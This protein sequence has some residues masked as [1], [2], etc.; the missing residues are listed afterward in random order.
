MNE[1]EEIFQAG[2]Q[3][4]R[5]GLMSLGQV[6]ERIAAKSADKARQA[7]EIDEAATR[8]TERA[9]VDAERAERDQV[10]QLERAQIAGDRQIDVAIGVARDQVRRDGWWAGADGNRV[11]T[12]LSLLQQLD[13]DPRAADARDIM[14]ERIRDLYGIDT[15]AISAKHPT[16]PIDQHNALTNAID[17]W[18]A[19][20]RED[21]LAEEERTK[22]AE[23][24]VSAG[25]G[26]D[27]SQEH[28]E[29]AEEHEERADA[30]RSDG[31]NEERQADRFEAEQHQDYTADVEA[32]KGATSNAGKA[33]AEAASGYPLSANQ[34]LNEGRKKGAPKARVNRTRHMKAG[35]ELTR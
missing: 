9:R 11:S 5:A 35:T 14:R 34:S 24:E 1:Q 15:D 20:H 18:R 32:V 6:G 2:D 8:L 26:V 13:G 21:A 12:Q 19:A 27:T 30:L 7:R 3:A 31:A 17:D 25:A 22:A 29:V 28:E 33:R 16:S 23:D 4:I 10:R